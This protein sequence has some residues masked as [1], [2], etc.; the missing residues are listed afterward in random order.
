LL[1]AGQDIVK[2][3]T[4]VAAMLALGGAIAG[5]TTSTFVPHR[6]LGS[7]RFVLVD[8]NNV[9]DTAAGVTLRPQSLELM[10]RRSPYFKNRLYVEPIADLVAE[11]RGNL[12]IKSSPS[13][14]VIQFESEDVDAALEVTRV[15]LSE[16]GNNA[17]RAANA[18]K[19]SEVIRIIKLPDARLT[20]LTPW[21]LTAIGL[22]AGLLMSLLIWLL[23]PSR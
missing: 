18:K 10:I 14:G 2:G 13:G 12:S 11:T 6:Y 21:L 7:A 4:R 9:F 17:A 19:A 8:P 1:R 16:F 5:F 15:T 20:G 22:T 23:L 3:I